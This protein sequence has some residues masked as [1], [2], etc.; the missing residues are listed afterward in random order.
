MFLFQDISKY[1]ESVY[2][3]FI[4]IV[5]MK[6]HK[7]NEWSIFDHWNDSRL[8][9]TILKWGKMGPIS[10]MPGKKW[11]IKILVNPI[12]IVGEWVNPPPP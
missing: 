3:D 1:H 2:L 10:R 6:R 8:L 9:V 5:F 4:Q 7:I 11:S 12:C